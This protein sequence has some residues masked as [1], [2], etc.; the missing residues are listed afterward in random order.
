MTQSLD[1]VTL[2]DLYADPYPTYEYLRR[3]RP[4]AWVPAANR[5]LVT[6]YADVVAVYRQP[7][8]FS[9]AEVPSLMTRVMGET[10]LRK[11]GKAHRRERAA[12]EA[13]LKPRAVKE[14]WNP[15]FQRNADTLIDRFADRGAADLFTEFAAPLAARNLAALLGLRGAS[16]TELITWSQALIDGGGNYDDDPDIWKRCEAA[17]EAIDE[18]VRESVRYLRGTPDHSVI[19][20][21]LHADDPL[22]EAQIGGNVKVMIGGGLNEPRDAVLVSTYA[23]LTH[24]AQ[25]EA[26]AQDPGL[27]KRVFEEAVR[28][29][30]PLGMNPRQVR[31]AA[32]LGGI[33]LQ[34]GDRLG[35]VVAS[36]NRDERVYAQPQVFDI[37]R[38][39]TQHVAFGGGPHFCAGIW[40]ARSATGQIA[41]PALFARLRNLALNP[42]EP[43]RFRG[44]VFRGPR[45]LPVCWTP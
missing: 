26:V 29:V 20:A 12:A 37:H 3:E 11:D 42:D 44:W 24:P 32:D 5:Y 16:E 22:S 21:M 38:K 2:S 14:R 41:V 28:W 43:V 6:R 19:S 4:V 9:S 35:V 10:L 7:E 31:Q 15:V 40:I 33:A 23:L 34:P 25:R 30:S 18:A 27:W 45:N 39:S 13:P 8:V 36:A 1:A 17:A